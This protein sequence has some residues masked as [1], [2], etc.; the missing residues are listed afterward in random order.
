[1]IKLE[2]KKASISAGFSVCYIGVAEGTRTLDNWNHNP[3]L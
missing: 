3:G 2:N 1:M